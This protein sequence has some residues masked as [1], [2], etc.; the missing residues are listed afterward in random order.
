MKRVRNVA[1]L[2]PKR[3][4][5]GTPQTIRLSLSPLN[6]PPHHS[7]TPLRSLAPTH[8]ASP[9]HQISQWQSMAQL[10]SPAPGPGCGSASEG[11]CTATPGLWRSW[12]SSGCGCRCVCTGS[13]SGSAAER[14]RILIA[15]GCRSG[16]VLPY[17]R[18]N[19]WGCSC[20]ALRVITLVSPLTHLAPRADLF[21]IV[22]L[23]APT[24][25]HISMRMASHSNLGG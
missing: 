8:A 10:A 17:M 1:G 18:Q 11:C 5:V 14:L 9:H 23:G 13:C 25:G 7:S 15:M 19:A 16:Q 12:W 22:P 3:C 21:H 2:A 20:F 24:L 6:L 4:W